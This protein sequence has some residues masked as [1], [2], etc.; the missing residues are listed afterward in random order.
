MATRIG[1]MSDSHGVLPKQIYS[2]FKDTDIIL[3]AGDIG[4]ADVID[5]LKSFKNTVAVYGNCDDR[6]MYDGI[7]NISVINIEKIKILMTH[8][9]GYPGHYKK[10]L[11]PVFEEIKPN[12]FICG[13]SHILKVMYDNDYHFLHINPG[14]CGKQGFHNKCTLVRFV[15]D[16]E[17]IKDLDVLSFNKYQQ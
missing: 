4:S 16:N 11:L 9:G 8:I 13:H 14:A 1:V 6:Y 5:E 3:H 15:I 10:E 17:N 12:I 7:K 2:F